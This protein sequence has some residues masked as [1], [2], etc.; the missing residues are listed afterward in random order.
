MGAWIRRNPCLRHRC[1]RSYSS[2]ILNDKVDG[3]KPV[4]VQLLGG[5]LNISW[6]RDETLYI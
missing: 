1:L 5:D 6:E 4:T 3:S 2:S